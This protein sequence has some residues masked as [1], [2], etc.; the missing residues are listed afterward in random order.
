MTPESIPTDPYTHTRTFSSRTPH[1]FPELI[2]MWKVEK[3]MVP[4]IKVTYQQGRKQENNLNKTQKSSCS[5]IK[6]QLAV[7]FR[8]GSDSFIDF[9]TF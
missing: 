6:T 1:A 9:I 5:T 7:E 3:V 8:V 2:K 4:L